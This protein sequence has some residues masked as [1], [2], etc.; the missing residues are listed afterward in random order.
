MYLVGDTEGR[1]A[2]KWFGMGSFGSAIG[3]STKLWGELNR[4]NK[5]ASALRRNGSS[6]FSLP[7][8]RGQEVKLPREW[9]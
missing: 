1:N 4:K 6:W 3:I 8:G 5:A 9:V 2:Q 7:Y